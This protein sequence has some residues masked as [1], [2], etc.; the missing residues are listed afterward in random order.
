MKGLK[1]VHLLKHS[2]SSSVNVSEG[3]PVRI[4]ARHGSVRGISVITLRLQN[5]SWGFWEPTRTNKNSATL[6]RFGDRHFVLNVLSVGQ[7][8]GGG[9]RRGFDSPR[10][11]G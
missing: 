1:Q 5:P 9:V 10:G 8:K 4:D 11:V 2:P 6:L 3:G 7:G